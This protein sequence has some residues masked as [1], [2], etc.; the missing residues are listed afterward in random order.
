ML[1]AA[2]CHRKHDKFLGT[3]ED[4]KA[5]SHSGGNRLFNSVPE[6]CRTFPECR[7]TVT[8][9]AFTTDVFIPLNVISL[10]HKHVKQMLLRGAKKKNLLSFFQTVQLTDSVLRDSL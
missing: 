2:Q 8:V 10:Q 9:E 3:Y 4:R 6:R 5:V 1:S 7:T